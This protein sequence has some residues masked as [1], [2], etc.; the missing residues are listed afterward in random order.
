MDTKN[1]LSELFN[2][3]SS[4]SESNEDNRETIM[5]F[6][7]ESNI[8]AIDNIIDRLF[9]KGIKEQDSDILSY[10]IKHKIPDKSLADMLK[11]YPHNTPEFKFLI[12]LKIMWIATS[13][14][15]EHILYLKRNIGWLCLSNHIFHTEHDISEFELP[16][17]L[18]DLTDEFFES[19]A[20][21]EYHN[22]DNFIK[23]CDS[24]ISI[25]SEINSNNVKNQIITLA[26]FYLNPENL[27]KA[28]PYL[29]QE[30]LPVM[31]LIIGISEVISI[32][33]LITNDLYNHYGFHNQINFPATMNWTL[34]DNDNNPLNKTVQKFLTDNPE[35]IIVDNSITIDHDLYHKFIRETYHTDS[36]IHGIILSYRIDEFLDIIKSLDRTNKYPLDL[37]Q[38]IPI[39]VCDF[40]IGRHNICQFVDS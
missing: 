35:T 11:K 19:T 23:Y 27:F 10:V 13:F 37:I 36:L 8:S 28:Q 25:F 15:D 40:V 39:V 32:F 12:T 17:D 21:L 18:D 4:D 2:A 31:K 14:D 29:E 34:D 22:S 5:E 7:N 26:N 33:L 1:N 30:G 24:A 3:D 6:D 20:Y 16:V 9:V 38:I